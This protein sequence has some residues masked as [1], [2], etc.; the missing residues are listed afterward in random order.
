[1][2]VRLIVSSLLILSI[3]SPPAALAQ[4]SQHV[5][6]SS[7]IKQAIA[8][9]VAVDRDTRQTV[10]KVLDRDDVRKIAAK[11]GLDV[12]RAQTAVAALEG[13]KLA[14]LASAA[15]SAE[16][17]LAGGSRVVTISVTTLLLILILVVLI[18]N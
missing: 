14:D 15:R 9:K 2:R 4:A 5:A 1:M 12:K 3:V 7:A 16:H 8:A 10:L 6:D 17:D 18:A 13:E 11:M